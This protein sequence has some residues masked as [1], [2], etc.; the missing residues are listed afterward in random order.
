MINRIRLA[1]LELRAMLYRARVKRRL[2]R[3]LPTWF[4][5][6]ALFV[7][8]THLGACAYRARMNAIETTVVRCEREVNEAEARAMLAIQQ[9]D[10]VEEVRAAVAAR[11]ISVAH[12]AA[13]IHEVTDARR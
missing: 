12:C 8:A 11:N 1:Y 7:Q 3:E 10:T 2:S 13:A 6:L 9:A 5:G 4:V